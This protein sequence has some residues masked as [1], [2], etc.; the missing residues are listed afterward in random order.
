M[1]SK[2]KLVSLFAGWSPPTDIQPRHFLSLK[3]SL[4]P[5]PSLVKVSTLGKAKKR[6]PTEAPFLLLFTHIFFFL[7][8]PV[9]SVFSFRVAEEVGDIQ[10]I[11]F[12]FSSCPEAGPL[13]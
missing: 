2:L 11:S 9:C 4:F 1:S 7:F 3:V 6:S 12:N 10:G 5:G 8:S 13:A